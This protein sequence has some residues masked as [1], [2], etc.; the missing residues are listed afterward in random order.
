MLF[1]KS[2]HHPNLVPTPFAAFYYF[3]YMLRKMI[4]KIENEVVHT[5]P[6]PL[7]RNH[8]GRDHLFER[9]TYSSS[10][11]HQSKFHQS[12]SGNLSPNIGQKHEIHFT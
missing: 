4:K 8:E 2:V 10:Y 3:F 1:F 11:H 7:L 6:P 12:F 5:P 9:A